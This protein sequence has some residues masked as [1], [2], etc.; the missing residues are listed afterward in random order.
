[1]KHHT[2]S[3]SRNSSGDRLQVANATGLLVDLRREF[4]GD[5]LDPRTR[6]DAVP[7]GPIRYSRTMRS[8]VSASGWPRTNMSVSRTALLGQLAPEV[9]SELVEAI[10]RGTADP[11]GGDSRAADPRCRTE[12]EAPW[13][14]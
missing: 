1:V 5:A 13:A 8:S 3:C 6:K 12:S 4:A 7:P 10:V 14:R 2:S 9:G 11:R